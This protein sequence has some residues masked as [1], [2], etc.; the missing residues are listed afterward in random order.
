MQNYVSIHKH[1]ARPNP[2]LAAVQSQAALLLRLAM[3]LQSI[4]GENVS[5]DEKS[6]KFSY[7]VTIQLNWVADE[8][9]RQLGGR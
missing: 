1:H 6:E 9:E 5:V 4:L 7:S 3:L 2:A 8:I